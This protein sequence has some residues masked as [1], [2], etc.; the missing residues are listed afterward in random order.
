M[1]NVPSR[2]QQ[3]AFT[4][5]STN[6]K[7]E[8]EEAED[9]ASDDSPFAVPTKAAQKKFDLAGRYRV[10]EG[11]HVAHGALDD[12]GRHTTSPGGSIV[13]LTHEEALSVIKLTKDQ[14]D[15]DGRPNVAIES[16]ATYMA[17]LEAIRQHEEFLK[18]LSD[19]N[20][21]AT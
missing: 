9:V 1:S 15:A 8:A 11:Y 19:N 14:K 16:E 5:P 13:H 2:R 6:A 21:I 18:A 4:A 10:R 20:A 17:R 12:N 3:S 7:P